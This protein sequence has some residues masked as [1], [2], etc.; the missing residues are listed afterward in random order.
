MDMRG[1]EFD[2]GSPVLLTLHSP[3]QKYFGVLL[4]LAAAGVEL[5]GVPL[6]SLEDLARQ[7]KNGDR[8]GASTLFFPM[9]RVEQMEIDAAVGELPSLGD[10]FAAQAGR[11]VKEVFGEARTGEECH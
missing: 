1:H 7:I 2:P 3:R 6:E 10:S 8:A 4:K 5:R 11:S 9:H